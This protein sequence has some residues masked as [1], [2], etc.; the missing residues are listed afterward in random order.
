MK[1]P[2]T[3]QCRPDNRIGN[4]SPLPPWRAPKSLKF[5]SKTS[6]LAAARYL[7]QPR[8]CGNPWDFTAAKAMID[9]AAVEFQRRCKAQ[10]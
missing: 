8:A 7:A 6:R 5:F 10:R 1:S 9:D 4:P 3:P 2:A